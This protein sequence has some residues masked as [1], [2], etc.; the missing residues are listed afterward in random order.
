[1][2]SINLE[3]NL[4][5][6][7]RQAVQHSTGPLLILAGAGSGK[8]RVLTHR[9]TRL[10]QQGL[11]SPMELLIVTF[12]NK[13]AR[14][15]AHRIYG[16]LDQMNYSYADRPWISTF[17]SACTRI[18]RSHGHRL[19]YNS[20]FSIYDSSEQLTLLKKVIRSLG[21][22]EEMYPPKT[23]QHR[24][25]QVKTQ[26]LTPSDVS[27]QTGFLMDR[28]SLQIYERYEEEM[29]RQHCMDFND[30][31]LK[32]YELFKNFP[33]VVQLYREQFKYIMVDEY[34][35]TNRLQYLLVQMLASQHRN[36]CVVGDEDQS[37]YSWRGADIQNILNFAKDFPECQTIKLEE[38]YRST[39]TIVQ[40]ASALIKNNRQR[41]DKT[42]FTQ[43]P[44]GTPITIHE[45][46]DENSE[47]RY[48]AKTIGQLRS[49]E[50]RNYSDFAVFYRMNAQSR[51]LEDQMR[52][53]NLPYR[54]V[55]TIR[56]YDRLE[57]KDIISYMTVLCNPSDSLAL[58]RIINRP[59]RGIGKV[60]LQKIEDLCD[61]QKIS[62]Y[63]ALEQ[64][65]NSESPK[66]PASKKI[67]RFFETLTKIKQEAEG[68]SPLG[69]YHLILQETGY[70]EALKQEGSQESEDRV[71]N[72]QELDNALS[73]FEKERGDEASLQSFLEE[74]ALISDLDMA[75]DDQPAVTLMT[76]HVSKGLEFPVVFVVGMEEGVFPSGRALSDGAPDDLEEERRIAYVGMTRAREKL[77]LSYA[78]IRH[79]WG[80]TQYS[81][82]SRFLDEIPEQLTQRNRS[83]T[84]PMTSSFGFRSSPQ[85]FKSES[86]YFPD[87]DNSSE[88]TTTSADDSFDFNDSTDFNKGMKVRHAHYGTGQILS[89]EGEGEWQK[90]VVLFSDYTKRKFVAKFA[91][92]ERL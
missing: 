40:G 91:K 18:L 50:N 86:S 19:G 79:L 14:E 60:T 11:A 26:G 90:L 59:A 67:Q 69:I 45:E 78:K 47:A 76:L 37:I 65:S 66:D 61:Q 77:H 63:T 13:A 54:L 15:M 56:F 24:I 44:M 68:L 49:Q 51:V 21:F 29:K 22:N 92:L 4:N 12:T 10:I 57:I 7:Q 89:V 74:V 30:L 48:V 71:A 43:N 32:T 73:E 33:E 31:L 64:I 41:N 84:A 28:R 17:H 88:A 6:M 36:L 34:Q 38:N 42:L 58:K 9:A 20:F 25:D 1:M 75:R 62:F 46:P 53:N 82:P 55:G 8:T 35:D 70:V 27:R 2:T 83:K 85:S 16:L 5:P 72:L 23:V 81:S 52:L 3:A 87:Y 39:Q 80:K